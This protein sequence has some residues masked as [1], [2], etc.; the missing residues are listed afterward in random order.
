MAQTDNAPRISVLIPIYNV[1]RYLRPCLDSVRAQTFA[2]FEAICINDGST[3]GSRAIIGKYLD[4]PRFRV[5]DKPNSG[6]GA[7]MNEGLDA[8]NGDY[9]AILESDDFFEP[10]ALDVLYS[11]AIEAQAEVA[12]AD[13]FFHWSQPAPRDER[14]PWVK[15]GDSG[16]CNPRTF[17]NVFYRKPSIW[18]A[19]YR[20]DFLRNHSIR[21]NETPGASYQ[22]SSFNFKVWACARRVVLVDR[23]ILHYRQDNESSSVN[24]PAK[25]F[26]VCDEYNEIMRFV[27]DQPD[28]AKLAPIVAKMRFDTY[29]WN[30]ERLTPEMREQFV[31]RMAEDFRKED[32]TGIID[33]KLLEP[34][35]VVD[36]KAIVA[37]PAA[38]FRV[39]EAGARHG[40]LGTLVRCFR[41][42][43]L[44]LV[45][46]AIQSKVRDG[47]Y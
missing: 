12:K 15:P 8:A 4:D 46:R 33:Y 10:D 6:Y 22:D 47:G 37:D 25:A 7:S 42:G 21:F 23:A 18:S 40:K 5:I 11:A 44:P 16:V 24:S 3:D 35:K 32:A 31:Y 29:M 1:E 45:A 13:F 14:F 34:W 27:N 26:C 30:Y 39:K 17:T 43:G 41:A 19:L 28:T 38:Y 9:V 36:R 2:D 20:R